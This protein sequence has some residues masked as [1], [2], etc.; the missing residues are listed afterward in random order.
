MDGTRV[1]PVLITLVPTASGQIGCTME[2]QDG[3]FEVTSERGPSAGHFD[4]VVSTLKPELEEFESRR[5]AN[6]PLFSPVSILAKYQ[7]AGALQ[8]EIQP[9]LGDEL[10]WV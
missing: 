6:Q 2:S 9:E 7:R 1:G 5:S 8:I 4:V 3:Q 10:K